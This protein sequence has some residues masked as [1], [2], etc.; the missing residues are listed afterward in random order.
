MIDVTQI[1]IVI[2]KLIIAPL[3]IWGIREGVAFLKTKAAAV[4]STEARDKI[5]YYLDMAAFAIQTA[6]IETQQTFVDS[7]KGTD[8]WDQATMSEA[9]A[10]SMERAKVI[11]GS[12]VYDGLTEAVGDVNE[13]ITAHIEQSV[14]ETKLQEVRLE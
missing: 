2:I 8:G 6:V 12:A 13:W 14:R 5:Q 3:L 7:I 1:I 10:R 4:Q 11:M 9:L